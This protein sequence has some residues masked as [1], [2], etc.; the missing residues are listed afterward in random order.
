MLLNERHPCIGSSYKKQIIKLLINIFRLATFWGI[1]VDLNG[2]QSIIIY[3]FLSQLGLGLG[4]IFL[5]FSF[6]NNI[7]F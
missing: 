3:A 6:H 5:N 2:N 7:I 4:S 1:L